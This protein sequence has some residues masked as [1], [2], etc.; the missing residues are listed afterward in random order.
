MVIELGE[1]QGAQTVVSAIEEY[2]TRLRTEI[3]RGKRRL[4]RFE[5][6]YNVSTDYFLENMAAED[7]EGNDL[8]Y[9]NWAGEAMLLAGLEQELSDLENARV[10]IY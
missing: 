9:V 3:A 6:K 7:L 10:D 2:K 8:E 5:K 4:A 1:K